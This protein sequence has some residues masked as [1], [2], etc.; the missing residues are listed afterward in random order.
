M[1]LVR[2]GE[3]LEMSEGSLSADE[4]WGTT[5]SEEESEGGEG[6]KAAAGAPS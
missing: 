4:S 6:S 2:A 1:K 5:S 3:C